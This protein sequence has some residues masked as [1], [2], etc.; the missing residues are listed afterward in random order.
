MIGRLVSLLCLAAAISIVL[1]VARRDKP[2][3]MWR[4]AWRLFGGL[5][6]AVIVLGL[7]VQ[8]LSRG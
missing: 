2:R 1:A 7:V 4:E 5:L 6:V 8:L 3:A